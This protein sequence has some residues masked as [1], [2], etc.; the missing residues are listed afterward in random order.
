VSRGICYACGESLE[1][2]SCE[3]CDDGL[4]GEHDCGEDTCCCRYSEPNVRCRDC[5]G[6][7]G[8]FVP[9]SECAERGKG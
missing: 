1:W 8:Y 5:D 9:H 4:T 3:N 6:D 2:R 7:G